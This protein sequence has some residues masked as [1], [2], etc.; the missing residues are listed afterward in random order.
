MEDIFAPKDS[1]KSIFEDKINIQRI[2]S[3]Y[4]NRWYWFIISTMIFLCASWLYI[5]YL[6]PIY[7][8]E[9]RVIIKDEGSKNGNNILNGLIS[10]NE[11][12]KTTDEIELLK[13]T[14]LTSR[15][16]D[17][18]DLNISYTKKGNVIET[19]LFG[20]QLPFHLELD[21][22]SSE[23]LKG[24]LLE[25][26]YSN[27]NLNILVNNTETIK[28]KIN[29]PFLINGYKAIFKSTNKNIGSDKI[30][31]IISD[32][33]SVSRSLKNILNIAPTYGSNSIL[34]ISINQAN[35][36][37]SEAII[38]NLIKVYNQDAINDR[39]IE[40]EK[41]AE[42][43]DERLSIVTEE[44]GNVENRKQDFKISNDIVS[45]ESEVESTAGA[46]T[47]L[48]N[49][50]L[51][52]ET[53][54]S[55]TST[56]KNYIA[57]QK[58]GEILPTNIGSNSGET[59][60]ISEYNRAVNKRNELLQS[61]ATLEHPEVKSLTSAL[62]ET[63]KN[64]ET[65]VQKQID[66]LNKTKNNIELELSKISTL[67]RKA[68]GLEKIARD[69]ERQQ[70]IK[71]NLYLL[72]LQKRE[73]TAINLAISSNKIK[74]IDPP[75]TSLSPIFPVK[76]NYFLIALALGIFLPFAII[77]ILELLKNKIETKEDIERLTNNKPVISEIPHL[78]LEGKDNIVKG[79]FS[80]LS[81]VFR[82]MRTNIEYYLPIQNTENGRVILVT[83]SIKGEGKTFVAMNYAHILSQLDDKKV[84]LIGADIRNPQLHRFDGS[85]KS[86]IGLTEYL[87][88]ND[89]N[90]HSYIQKSSFDD[91]TDILFSGRIPPNPTEMLMS[92]KFD[93]LIRD[94]KNEYDYVIIDS[95][96]VVLVS[97]TFH[98]ADQAEATIY[99]TRSDYTPKN[100]LKVPTDA[101]QSGKLKNI[102]F[103][104]NDIKHVN[105]GSS[106]GYKY[107]YG[108]GYGYHSE[109][110]KKTLW[111]KI[112]KVFSQNKIK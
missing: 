73:E 38:N 40:F 79:D 11:N 4:I 32:K 106:Y 9:A 7:S 33:A 31:V 84:I 91:K 46:K 90:Y 83:S 17:N 42:F 34:N 101:E 69:I 1:T 105:S 57:G 66:V 107:N 68:P 71:E 13:S 104:L 67:K 44:L 103:V 45:I 92:A 5:R 75:F 23:H 63:K 47:S 88:E 87:Y 93:A 2:L 27:E 21:S 76:R 20:E 81:E 95:A 109:G 22:I 48:E 30:K 59:G 96:P 56:Y 10:S 6:I 65:S 49:K 85:T 19:E 102:L 74:I 37:K 98:I 14:S 3:A 97:D 77:Y 72:L 70:Q 64:I 60:S 39:N 15:V 16:I 54:I 110:R 24:T 78:K 86:R 51:E 99:V 35:Y 89:T 53:N 8:T 25:V 12:N 82:I 112:K 26:T 29:S 52:L 18:L 111:Q 41:T 80:E 58:I 43:I 108:Y 28:S 36:L 50:L 100:I 62:Q 94:L 55:L 61:G